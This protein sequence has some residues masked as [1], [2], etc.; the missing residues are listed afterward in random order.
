MGNLVLS[1]TKE[2]KGT[3]NLI[4]INADEFIEAQQK[5]EQSAPLIQKI[6]NGMNNKASDLEKAPMQLVPVRRGFFLMLVE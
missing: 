2:D 4:K 1:F 3:M 5:I 6:E